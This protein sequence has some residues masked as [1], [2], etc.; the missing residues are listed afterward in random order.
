MLR[1]IAAALFICALVLAP[2]YAGQ[3]QADYTVRLTAPAGATGTTF[4]DSTIKISFPR[5]THLT[6]TLV[7]KTGAPLEINWQKAVFLD[8]NGQS[9][10]VVHD[11]VRNV[12]KLDRLQPTVVAPQASLYATVVPA[13]RITSDPEAER[14]TL[15]TLYH[16][17]LEAYVNKPFSLRLPITAGGATTEYLFTFVVERKSQGK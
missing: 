14:W 17:G 12:E 4:E 3:G 7:N 13:G 9:H 16:G 10:R 2:T 15:Q 6:F 1:K 5:E 8:G 11:D